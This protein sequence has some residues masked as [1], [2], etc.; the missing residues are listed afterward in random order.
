M[1][2]YISKKI[3]QYGNGY[4][5]YMRTKLNDLS[6]SI[7]ISPNEMKNYR[8]RRELIDVLDN[9]ENF[10]DVNVYFIPES[11]EPVTLPS[12]KQ[13]Y[14]IKISNLHNLRFVGTVKKDHQAK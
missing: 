3:T 2:G 6:V 4:S 5:I 7:Y 12:G 9:I 11:I 10:E 13:V 1:F 14:Q 8:L